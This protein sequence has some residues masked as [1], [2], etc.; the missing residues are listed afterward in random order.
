[1]RTGNHRATVRGTPRN[2][3]VVLVAELRAT[4]GTALFDEA[5]LD[6]RT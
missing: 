4:A 5:L 1:M 2:T 6:R 3:T